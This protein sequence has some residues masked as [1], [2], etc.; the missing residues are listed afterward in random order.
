MITDFTP[1]MTFVEEVAL[2][3]TLVESFA[4]F[5][6][7]RNPLHLEADA[8]RDY[9]FA[10]PVAHG[11]IQSAIVSRLIG[12]KCPGHGA[13]WMSQSMVWLKPAFVGDTIRVEVEVASV[14][15]GAE[16]LTLRL[17]AKNQGG[18]DLM[19]GSAQVK[20]ASKL[21]QQ[22]RVKADEPR[23]ALITGGSRGI[24]AAMA[25]ALAKAGH[26][27]AIVYRTDRSSAE[28]VCK[29]CTTN[30]V[31][32]QAYNFDLAAPGSGTKLVERV[33]RDFGALHVIAHCAT[34]PVQPLALNEIHS[35]QLRAYHRLHVEAAL[36]LVQAAMPGMVEQRFGRLLFMGTAYLFGAPPAK[37]AAY[38]AAKQGLW[39][40]VRSLA[41]ELGPHQITANMIS[42]GMTITDLTADI[43]QRMKEAEARKVPLR[44][45]AVPDDIAQTAAFLASDAAGYIN[46][47]NLPLTGGPV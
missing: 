11:A 24:G 5:S 42:P 30:T 34:Q 36:E 21:A 2:T 20:V 9:G 7:D 22:A 16:T 26:H 44:R 14:S 33:L 15:E 13:V 37:L 39:G 8:A 27:V 28:Y 10:R 47:Q 3:P 41:L 6:G 32:A 43:P 46:G 12:M 4:Q 17:S 18:D 23:V 38:I 31:R 19:H 40:L 25:E 1:G 29:A 45:L 35:D